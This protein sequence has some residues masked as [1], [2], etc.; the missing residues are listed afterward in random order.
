MLITH[1]PQEILISV[2]ENT[3]LHVLFRNIYNPYW[4]HL[5]KDILKKG[6]VDQECWI[7]RNTFYGH[8]MC[9]YVP[10]TL[11]EITYDTKYHGTVWNW[12][13]S[14]KLTTR[15]T[16]MRNMSIYDG[17]IHIKLENNILNWVHIFSDTKIKC[18]E[19][20]SKSDYSEKKKIC[21]YDYK[22]IPFGIGLISC[23]NRVGCYINDNYITIKMT[24]EK[25]PGMNISVYSSTSYFRINEQVDPIYIFPPIKKKEKL[26]PQAIEY[27][28]NTETNIGYYE[29]R[30]KIDI[31]DAN[32][33]CMLRYNYNNNCSRNLFGIEVK[34]GTMTQL[35]IFYYDVNIKCIKLGLCK[36]CNEN[37]KCKKC[38]ECIEYRKIVCK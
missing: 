17:A 2:F 15:I 11:D 19:I 3:N 10:D 1:F 28:Q 24:F 9:G 4:G 37:N 23:N 20:Y 38:P 22:Y 16:Q 32:C 18:I 35:R 21:A 6:K 29:V 27:I 5:I 30:D 14:G 7:N 8:Q 34:D 12:K 33:I 13:K 26:C 36:S 31:D 25:Y